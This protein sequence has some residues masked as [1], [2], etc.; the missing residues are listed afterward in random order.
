MR[1]VL[2]WACN[3]SV[4]F[5]AA[6]LDQ[7]SSRQGRSPAFCALPKQLGHLH[8]GTQQK[9]GNLLAV[10]LQ[11]SHVIGQTALQVL[12]ALVMCALNK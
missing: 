6:L 4:F 11:A 10:I 12:H 1:L 8:F 7:A 3:M 2:H 5:T 9:E